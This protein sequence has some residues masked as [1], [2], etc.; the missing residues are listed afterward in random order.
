MK[1]LLHQ[2]YIFVFSLK[3][4]PIFYSSQGDA[5]FIFLCWKTFCSNFSLGRNEH[6]KK[7]SKEKELLQQITK[8][9]NIMI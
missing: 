4:V 3:S 7:Y 8:N 6:L 2:F 9:I 1:L 5:E